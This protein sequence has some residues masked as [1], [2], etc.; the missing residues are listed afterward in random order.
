MDS[1]EVLVLQ[2]RAID[3]LRRRIAIGCIVKAVRTRETA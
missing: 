1:R 2:Q 3:D